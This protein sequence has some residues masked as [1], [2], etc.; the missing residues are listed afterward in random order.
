MILSCD[1]LTQAEKQIVEEEAIERDC[2]E[3]ERIIKEEKEEDKKEEDAAERDH[4]QQELLRIAAD[5][6][7]KVSYLILNSLYM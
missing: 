7:A 6:E 3:K 4:R 5:Q 1:T 2:Q